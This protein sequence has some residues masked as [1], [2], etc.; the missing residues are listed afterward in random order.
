MTIESAKILV[1]PGL[2]CAVV[3]ALVACGGPEGDDF[4]DDSAAEGSSE[5]A[6]L[7]VGLR[8]GVADTGLGVTAGTSDVTHPGLVQAAGYLVEGDSSPDPIPARTADLAAAPPALPL[9]VA[10]CSRIADAS[11]RELCF[12]KLAVRRAAR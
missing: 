1:R 10:D 2:L 3:L 11:W 4:T 5:Q 6:I 7:D 8:Q 9:T 12:R